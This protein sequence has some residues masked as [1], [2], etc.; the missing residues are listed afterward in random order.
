MV[1]GVESGVEFRE[2]A[3]DIH[4]N[5]LR[6]ERD[7]C[8]DLEMRETATGERWG[9]ASTTRSTVESGHPVES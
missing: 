4:S 6:A 3:H 8:T 2:N 1:Y 5:R 9:F 7:S